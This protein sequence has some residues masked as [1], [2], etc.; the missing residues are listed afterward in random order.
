M[1]VWDISPTLLCRAHL[2]G[3][4][5]EIHAISKIIERGPTSPYYKHP[6]VQRWI[7]QEYKLWLRHGSVV[8]D[9]L[10]RGYKH[11]SPLKFTHDQGGTLKLIN[12]FSEQVKILA[13]KRA[14]IPACKC[15]IT[16]MQFV[17]NV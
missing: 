14:E 7:E 9:M 10:F 1:R 11:K 12:T 6:E 17:Y 8:D 5:R 16:S 15:D 3:E 13:Q 2:L 4:H